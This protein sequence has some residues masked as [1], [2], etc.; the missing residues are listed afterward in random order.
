[1]GGDPRES[2][3]RRLPEDAPG[4]DL[5]GTLV[6][7]PVGYLCVQLLFLSE[8]IKGLKVQ[9]FETQEDGAKG[10]AVKNPATSADVPEQQTNEKGIAK[11][12]FPVPTGLYVC[13]IEHQPETLITTVESPEQPFIVTL[14]VGRPVFDLR[15]PG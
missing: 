8:P 2:R 4:G 15:P 7:E 13:R 11:V 14:P 3:V 6:L 10:A 5:S 1:M 9:F 12:D